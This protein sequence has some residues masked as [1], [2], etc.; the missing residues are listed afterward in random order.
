MSDFNLKQITSANNADKKGSYHHGGGGIVD[1]KRGT[2]V[3][4]PGGNFIFSQNP[5]QIW[6]GSLHKVSS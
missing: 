1:V 2:T 5:K 6:K 4:I 3:K